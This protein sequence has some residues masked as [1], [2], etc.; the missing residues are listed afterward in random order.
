MMQEILTQ[1]QPEIIREVDLYHAIKDVFNFD[2][3]AGLPCGELKHFIAESNKD[4][5]IE[6]IQATN[7]RE[8]IG[9]AHGA[10]LAGKTPSL[11]MQNSGLFEA[12]NDLGSLLLPCK[13]PV[14][15]VVSWRGA[16]GETAT[17]HLYT[18]NATPKLLEAFGIPYVVDPNKNKLMALVAVMHKLEVPGVVL[19]KKEKFN[20]SIIPGV[21][22]HQAHQLDSSTFSDLGMQ[23]ETLSREESLDTIF[24]TLIKSDD[25]V[26]TSTGLISRYA[27]HYHDSDNQFY[28]AGAFGVTSMIGL[29]FAH[30]RK[31][32]RTIVV[33][34]DGSV[35]TNLGALNVIG[36]YAG[37]N[38]THVVLDNSA[39]V[40]CSGEAT[41]GS[42]SIPNLA[43]ELG[44]K[45]VN[46][47]NSESELM[48]VI[49]TTN[50]RVNGPQM[51]HIRINQK[52]ERDFRRPLEMADIARR[53]RNKFIQLP[54]R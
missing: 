33:E 20:E 36:H 21:S 4:S 48:D 27:F 19:V 22:T 26:F 24:R 10:W 9:L 1:N 35:L 3:V 29:G 15:F 8:S 13:V 11:Y 32:V 49:N 31:D 37:E 44:Y 5:S 53:L 16:P 47:V 40:S 42:S 14:L 43:R 7:E 17:Q 50:K 39:Y 6:H 25:A 52:G 18:G 38:F 34:G 46:S 28:N 23:S 45:T 41:Y 12:S 2:F 51:I 30:S 54:R